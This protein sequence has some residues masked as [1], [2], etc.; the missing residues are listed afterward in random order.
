[1][2]KLLLNPERV[3]AEAEAAAIRSMMS[4]PKRVLV[5]HKPEAPKAPAAADAKAG[6]KGTLHKPPAGTVAAK[7]A[8]PAAGGPANAPAGAGKEVKSAKLSSSWAG[9]PAKK[10][11]IPTRGDTGAGAGRST[12]WRTGPRGRRGSNDRDRDHHQTAS[13]PVEA[14]VLEVHARSSNT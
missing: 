1:V 3:P 13:A 4:A 6:M 8:K 11:A 12:N 7:P 5:A 2:K 10:K 9:D 14:R